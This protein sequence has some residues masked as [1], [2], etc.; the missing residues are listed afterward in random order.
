MTEKLDLISQV[1][2]A[3]LELNGH[4]VVGGL[5]KQSLI[6]FVFEPLKIRNKGW[7]FHNIL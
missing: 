4:R 3:V 2:L 6:D 1:Q 5:S 7:L